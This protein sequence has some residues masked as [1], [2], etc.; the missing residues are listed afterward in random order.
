MEKQP[1]KQLNKKQ[2][3]S[4]YV[5]MKLN[6]NPPCKKTKITNLIIFFINYF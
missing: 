2:N 4:S 1:E 6:K 5:V 3:S